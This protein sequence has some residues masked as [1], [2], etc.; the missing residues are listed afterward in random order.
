MSSTKLELQYTLL[1][2]ETVLMYYEL[3]IILARIFHAI[4]SKVL[5]IKINGYVK[6]HYVI[7]S[8]MQ[9]YQTYFPCAY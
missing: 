8:D 3:E 4:M 7:V 5:C 9:F 1:F 6:L 2:V